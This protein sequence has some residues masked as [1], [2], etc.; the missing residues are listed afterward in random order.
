MLFTISFFLC[1]ESA[2]KIEKT[3]K[4]GDFF[5]NSL[6]QVLSL[7]TVLYNASNSTKNVTELLEA[8]P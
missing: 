7:S 3:C 2:K 6:K 1:P 8:L 5:E 4:I